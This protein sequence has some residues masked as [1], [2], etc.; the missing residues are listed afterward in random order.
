MKSS[1]YVAIYI[2]IIITA[3]IIV[4]AILYYQNNRDVCC[5]IQDQCFKLT[6]TECST[7]KDLFASVQTDYTVN[8]LIGLQEDTRDLKGN[9]EDIIGRLQK[10]PRK[11][12]IFAGHA[13]TTFLIV[14][15]III[16]CLVSQPNAGYFMNMHR[17]D[18]CIDK[19][20][21]EF[22]QI[23]ELLVKAKEEKPEKDIK[24]LN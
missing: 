10:I 4:G 23:R 1:T 14:G 8:Q 13:I 17:V 6:T 5:M 15:V 22:E 3:T 2:A 16:S 24:D 20:R 12:H 18:I 11:E 9:L 21:P 7:L 19:I